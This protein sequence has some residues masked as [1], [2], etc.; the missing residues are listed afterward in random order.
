M[1][2]PG[3]N[4]SR[5]SARKA[6][7]TASVV[8]SVVDSVPCSRA[9]TPVSRSGRAVAPVTAIRGPSGVIRTAAAQSG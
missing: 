5:G 7:S 1:P 2:R 3:T 4:S 9:S 6:A 8:Y